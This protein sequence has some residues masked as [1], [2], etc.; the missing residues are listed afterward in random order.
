[1]KIINLIIIFFIFFNKIVL[2][3]IKPNGFKGSAGK[4]MIDQFIKSDKKECKEDCEMTCCKE[5]TS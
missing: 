2:A 1:M 3:E 5:K 4:F